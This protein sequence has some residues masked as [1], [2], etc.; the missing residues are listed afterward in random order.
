M[1]KNGIAYPFFQD[2]LPPDVLRKLRSVTHQARKSALGVWADDV[3]DGFEFI[4]RDNKWS[5]V[6]AY[7][8]LLRSVCRF[9]KNNDDLADFPAFMNHQEVIELHSGKARRFG[10]FL[11]VEE[12]R[13][14]MTVAPEEILFPRTK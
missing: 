10:E 3:T 7:P 1:L 9:L 8:Y 13:I 11:H 4:P 6:T 2:D 12:A 5:E 14:R